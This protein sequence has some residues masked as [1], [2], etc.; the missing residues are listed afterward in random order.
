MDRKKRDCSLLANISVV[1]GT[2][3][4]ET[5]K[6]LLIETNFSLNKCDT[7]KSSV[8]NLFSLSAIMN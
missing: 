6:V 8:F 2:V 5:A 7:T 4:N 1:N 3:G